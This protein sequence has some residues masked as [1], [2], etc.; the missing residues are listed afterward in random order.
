M[1]EPLDIRVVEGND[2]TLIL[3]LKKRTFVNSKPI[4]E[5][6]IY[7]DLQDVVLTIGSKEYQISLGLD[8]VSTYVEG[9]PRGTYNVIL[10]ATYHG[11][12]I[13]AAY[14]Q[15]L[16]SVAWNRNSNAEQFL[17]GSPITMD[18]AF[19]IGGPLTDAELEELKDEYREKNVQLAQAIED[20]ADAK[21]AFDEAAEALGDLPQTLNSQQG[22]ID[23]QQNTINNQQGLIEQLSGGITMMTDA[24]Y[25]PA[26]SDLE[27]MLD[28]INVTA[29]NQ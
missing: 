16:H 24:E 20:A 10:S 12:K 19:I 7:A 29:E 11:A 23:S 26:L 6:I 3:P 21:E 13:R 22:T 17:P 14:F 5:P 18:A 25:Q 2:F 27:N 9:L 4:D 15:E 8:G 28:D 1:Q